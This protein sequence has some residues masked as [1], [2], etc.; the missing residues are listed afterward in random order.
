[1]RQSRAY[2]SLVLSVLVL[3]AALVIAQDPLPALDQAAAEKLSFRNDVQP[4]LKRHCWGCHSAAKPEGGLKLDTVADMLKGG[5]TGPLFEPGKPDESSLVK[6]IIG[7]EPEMP[8]KQPP[9]S[10]AKIQTLRHW[11]LAGAKDDSL[12]GGSPLT[13]QIP[14]AY[15]SPP[16]VTSVALSPDGKLLAAACRSEVVLIEVDAESAPRQFADRSDL[17]THVEFNSDGS[18]LAA[19]GGSPAQFGDVRFS[20]RRMEWSFRD[21]EWGMTRCSEAISLPTENRS[22]SEARTE[23]FTSSRWM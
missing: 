17:L 22:P 7:S 12:P 23:R 15:L 13:I 16:A 6:M 19:A 1:M 3:S 2:S 20:I 21:A 18:L 4:I 14:Q 5:D 10:V 11:I 8:K 9:L